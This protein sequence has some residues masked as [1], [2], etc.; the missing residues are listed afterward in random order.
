MDIIGTFGLAYLSFQE[1]RE[2]FD[3][4]KATRITRVSMK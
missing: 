4:V 3:K 2:C 1:A